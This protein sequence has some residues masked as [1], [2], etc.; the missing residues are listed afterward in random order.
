MGEST[1]LVCMCVC[2]WRQP[3]VT[4]MAAICEASAVEL[5][6]EK[7]LREKDGIRERERENTWSEG[8]QKCPVQLAGMY[9]LCFI[10]GLMFCKTRGTTVVIL[11]AAMAFSS[12]R[13]KAAPC[14]KGKSLRWSAKARRQDVFRPASCALFFSK[15]F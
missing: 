1:T 2:V 5:G 14:H 6:R 15:L 12:G 3:W 10:D 13:F 8:S 9:L 4:H 7:V 11:W